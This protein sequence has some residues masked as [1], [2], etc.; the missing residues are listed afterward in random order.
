MTPG[1]PGF[2]LLAI[3]PPTGEPDP[4]CVDAWLEAGAGEIGIALLLRTPGALVRDIHA[5][6]RLKRIR[7]A[8]T[9]RAVPMLI[10]CAASD[11]DDLPKGMTDLAGL[12]VRGDPDDADLARARYVSRRGGPLG[13][14]VHG[15]TPRPGDVDYTVFAPVFDPN[16]AQIGTSKKASGLAALAAW[17]KA[18]DEP[19]FALGGVTAERGPACVEAGARGL[20]GISAFF[21]RKQTVVE[22]VS[23]FV[24]ALRDVRTT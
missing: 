14:S 3:T 23:A 6:P 8:C 16:T 13:R 2:A 20:A 10:S 9:D 18:V 4:A 11:L 15:P 7:S 21:G 12:Q 24:A 17:A 5:D 22:T 1:L 19:V